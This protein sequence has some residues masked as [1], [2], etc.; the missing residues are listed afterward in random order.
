MRRDKF[1]MLDHRVRSGYAKLAGDHDA[2]IARRHA[3]E[4]NTGIHDVLLN[5]VDAPEKIEV[6]PRPAELAIGDRLQPDLFLLL[7]DALDLAVFDCLEFGRADLALGALR[8]R[9]MQRGGTQQAADMV[10]AK[11]RLGALHF[12]PL[13][14]G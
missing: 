6:P 11:R 3:H 7:D 4:R 13:L 9:L 2:L 12:S 8:A 14:Q 1:E 10:G 5:A